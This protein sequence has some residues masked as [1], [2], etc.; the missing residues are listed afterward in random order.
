MSSPGEQKT[1]A[2]P[3]HMTIR[4]LVV[5]VLTLAAIAGLVVIDQRQPETDAA[6]A[7]I[8]QPMPF[9][10][11]ESRS[12]ANWFCPGVPASD[13]QVSS[14]I[15]VSNA[16]DADLAATITFMGRSTTTSTGVVVPAR[17]RATVDA[18]SLIHI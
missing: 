15:V 11:T 16:G 17:S 8:D 13:A 14:S 18:L 1:V 3:T 5:M 10:H 12:A 6:V 9:V 4:Q 2:Q 7:P